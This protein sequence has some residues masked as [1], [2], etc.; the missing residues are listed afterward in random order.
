MLLW[1]ALLPKCTSFPLILSQGFFSLASWIIWCSWVVLRPYVLFKMIIFNYSRITLLSCWFSNKVFLWPLNIVLCSLLCMM[2]PVFSL[3]NMC[4][5]VSQ[6]MIDIDCVHSVTKIDRFQDVQAKL[7]VQDVVWC[8]SEA[9]QDCFRNC[10]GK[11]LVCDHLDKMCC[12]CCKVVCFGLVCCFYFGV[13]GE[14]VL[15]GW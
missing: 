13:L 15:L 9:R 3:M 10:T 8:L 5:F 12:Q 14:T 11:Q 7:A 1:S 4:I 2:P 6:S